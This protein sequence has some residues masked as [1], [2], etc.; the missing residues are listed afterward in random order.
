MATEVGSAPGMPQLQSVQKAMSLP[1]VG[2]AVGQVGAFYTKVKGAHSLLEWALSTAEASVTLAATTAAPYVAAQLVA[3]D[4][5]VAAALDALERRVP[6]VTEQPKVI[7][8]TT[9]QAVLSKITPQLNKVIGARDV[10]EQRVK[11]LKELTW[12]KANVLL[13]TAYGQK[14][15]HGVDSGAAYAWQLLDRYLPPAAGEASAV[16]KELVPLESDPALHTMQTVGRLSAVAAR[17][18]WANLSARLQQL[19]TNGIELDVRRYVTALLAALHLA[20]VTSQQQQ[21]QQEPQPQP[22]EPTANGR[23]DAHRT[24]P[25]APTTTELV[26]CTPEAKSDGGDH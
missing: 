9:K 10:A 8:E 22:G 17:R 19:K 15:L 6:L 2:A 24:A 11:S 14:A 12:A 20:R 4:A 1:A 3:G 21:Q 26:K 5:K 23:P 16:S 13:A 25:S 18:V 7:V